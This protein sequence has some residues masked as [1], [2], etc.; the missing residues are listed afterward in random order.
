MGWDER[1]RHLNCPQQNC[2]C[3]LSVYDLDAKP[4]GADHD[5]GVLHVQLGHKEPNGQPSISMKGHR[6]CT[7]YSPVR[8]RQVNM[9]TLAV[10]VGS[11]LL[12]LAGVALFLKNSNSRGADQR[13]AGQPQASGACPT[14]LAGSFSSLEC[15][16]GALMLR[17]GFRHRNWTWVRPPGA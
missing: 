2:F 14:R 15:W 8:S 3:H 7:S 12:I 5:G 10:A 6:K 16:S 4:G 9:L 13:D 17:L 1:F 11:L